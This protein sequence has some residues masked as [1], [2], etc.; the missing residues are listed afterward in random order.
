[1]KLKWILLTFRKLLKFWNIR[2]ENSYTRWFMAS[3]PE[4]SCTWVRLPALYK[5]K[6][7]PQ[8]VHWPTV[9]KSDFKRSLKLPFKRMMQGIIGMG[10]GS[11][12]NEILEMSAYSPEYT[13]AFVQQ[14]VKI[15][16]E[17]FETVFRSFSD[18]ISCGFTEDIRIL[19]IDGS[20]MQIATNPNDVDFFFWEQT[21]RNH[22]IF[23]TWTHYMT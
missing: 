18:H 9:K 19:A 6:Y 12:T 4:T 14:R 10:G 17:A 8:K 7:Y 16:P 15:K 2:R 13:S 20:A 11:L 1:M 3:L 23:C 22:T 5:R 21:D